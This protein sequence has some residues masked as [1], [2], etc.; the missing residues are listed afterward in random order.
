MNKK[1]S[2]ISPLQPATRQEQANFLMLAW[3]RGLAVTI[4]H[5]NGSQQIQQATDRIIDET[6]KLIHDTNCGKL[7]LSKKKK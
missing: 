7:H 2:T 4:K 6:N 5:Q 1:H 3:I